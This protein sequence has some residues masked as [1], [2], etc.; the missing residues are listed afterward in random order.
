MR[1]CYGSWLASNIFSGRGKKSSIKY[2]QE[3]KVPHISEHRHTDCLIIINMAALRRSSH[4]LTGS[5]LYTRDY[6]YASS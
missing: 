4:V 3:Q 1:P 2:D 6:D 5:H